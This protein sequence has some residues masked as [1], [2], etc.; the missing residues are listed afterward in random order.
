MVA[1]GSSCPEPRLYPLLLRLRMQVLWCMRVPLFTRGRHHFPAR[2]IKKS[3]I[4]RGSAP[5]RGA[6]R[7]R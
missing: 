4:R 3:P 7:P 2:G 5:S 1:I 6:A